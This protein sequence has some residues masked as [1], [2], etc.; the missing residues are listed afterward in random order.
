[1]RKLIILCL[2]LF[3]IATL[4]HPVYSDDKPIKLGVMFIS[5]G[6]LGGYGINGQRATEMAVEE[7]N[8]SGGVLGR[9]LVATFGDT[10]L[11]PEVAVELAQKFISEDK[12][13]FL[14]DLLLAVSHGPVG[15]GA[16][17]QENPHCDASSHGRINR[18][19]VQP[20]SVQHT[21]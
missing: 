18:S 12:V 20:L 3:L 13:D 6:P 7:I 16:K 1:M 2:G 4:V 17:A 21:E 15:D 10:K 11:K 8:G 9:K 14:M 5:S 19:Q